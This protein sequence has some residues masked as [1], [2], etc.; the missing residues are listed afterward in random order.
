MLLRTWSNQVA[1]KN[2]MIAQF[3]QQMA[4]FLCSSAVKCL[5]QLQIL[6]DTTVLILTIMLSGG[7]TDNKC[8]RIKLKT[9]NFVF[10]LRLGPLL[11]EQGH[12]RSA[13]LRAT[14]C[15]WQNICDCI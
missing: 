12:M 3:S 15:K 1:E 2:P 6:P 10:Y 8:G 5:S 13:E 9:K 11:V 14:S 7:W 4:D